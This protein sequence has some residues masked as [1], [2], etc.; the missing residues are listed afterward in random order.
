M[1][2]WT[3]SK[4]QHFPI[5]LPSFFAKDANNACCLG[6]RQKANVTVGLSTEFCKQM[7][8][9]AWS[10]ETLTTE[11]CHDSSLSCTPEQCNSIQFLKKIT[12]TVW[13]FPSHA[14]KLGTIPAL[15]RWL[16]R[17]AIQMALH[18]MEM[19]QKCPFC[20]KKTLEQVFETKTHAHLNPVWQHVDPTCNLQLIFVVNI[21]TFC[22]ANDV[23]FQIWLICVLAWLH[24]KLLFDIETAFSHG[25]F[26][27]EKPILMHCP[28]GKVNHS[29]QWLLVS[30]E[31]LILSE[32]EKQ[33]SPFQL[34]LHDCDWN[35]I[36]KEQSRCL[37]FCV[38]ECHGNLRTW[39]CHWMFFSCSFCFSALRLVHCAKSC[40]PF[41]LFANENCEL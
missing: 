20:H 30:L 35:C 41:E 22:V 3:E 36:K 10:S 1:F 24:Q 12:R 40:R 9:I 32:T 18:K 27:P 25:R 26:G 33:M 21:W 13:M 23:A 4:I 19:Q 16:R 7:F 11:W 28:P 39:Q 17:T 8:G 2:A 6:S 37:T 29:E 38:Q 34:V 14:M 5:D 15:Q 31:C